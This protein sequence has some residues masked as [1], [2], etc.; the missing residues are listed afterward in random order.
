MMTY[1][2]PKLV[3]VAAAGTVIQAK[4]KGSSQVYDMVPEET[5]GAYQADE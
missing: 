3:M 2:K 4:L 5:I 1:E